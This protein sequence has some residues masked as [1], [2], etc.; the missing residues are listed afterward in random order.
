MMTLDKDMHQLLEKDRITGVMIQY[1]K[2]CLR[3]L[4][5]YIHKIDFNKEHEDIA[6]GRL[7]HS[8]SYTRKK[9]NIDLDIVKIDVLEDSDELTILEVKKST[10]M[11]EPAR[12]Q[13]LYYLQLLD[14]I[15]K[16]A[17]GIIA[18]PKEKKREV[19]VLTPQKKQELNQI[20]E[21]VRRIKKLE[22]PP[23][24]VKLPHCKGCSYY[25]FCWV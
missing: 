16:K 10:K 22:K 6:I 18:I 13:L 20:L 11:I 5:L 24:A 1:Y 17:I 19:V 15:G 21:D 8:L 25:E 9:R 12:Y 2:S 14:C 3:E 4:W 23:I 7:I